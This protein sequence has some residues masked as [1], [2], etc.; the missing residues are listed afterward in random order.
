MSPRRSVAPVTRAY[1]SRT[2]NPVTRSFSY[3][4]TKQETNTPPDVDWERLAPLAGT[5]VSYAGGAQLEAI[6]DELLRHGRPPDE[7]AA[8][9]LNGTLPN[10]RTIQG[11][12]AGNSSGRAR[13]SATW[14]RGARRRARRR[15]AGPP[16]MVRR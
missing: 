10:Q 11:T 1:P 4:G 6:I 5:L 3:A 2:P 14:L 16:A 8:L 15:V 12:F 9:I 13:R 7:P